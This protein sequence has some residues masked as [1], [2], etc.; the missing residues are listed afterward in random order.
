MNLYFLFL[1]LLFFLLYPNYL[2]GLTRD[3]TRDFYEIALSE[4]SDELNNQTLGLF[5]LHL[6]RIPKASSTA[7][8]TVAR[9]LVGC[10]PPGPCCKFPGDPVGSCPDKRLFDC[11]KQ[12]KVIG[13]IHHKPFIRFLYTHP[14][15]PTITMLRN[16]ISR[17]VSAFSH[18][19]IHCNSKCTSSLDYCFHQYTNSSGR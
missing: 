1:F 18:G 7:L 19:G 8:S 11:E 4:L 5:K 13:C 17:S 3:Y 9:R 2:D 6:I 16:P 15:T 12:G 10:D 14:D